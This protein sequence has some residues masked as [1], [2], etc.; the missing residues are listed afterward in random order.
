M[1]PTNIA[2]RNLNDNMVRTETRTTVHRRAMRLASYLACLLATVQALAAW[3]L[4][5][6][7]N[8]KGTISGTIRQGTVL[9]MQSGSAYEVTDLTLQ[10][11]LE[12]LP[13][14]VILR[15][16][17]RYKLYIDGFGESLRPRNSAA[18]PGSRLLAFGR[19]RQR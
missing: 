4:Y 10:L 16:G 15:D 13:D 8:V 3:S 9:R 17:V 12:I 6:E 5:E 7:T 19:E 2:K 11:V 1:R 18:L 14:A